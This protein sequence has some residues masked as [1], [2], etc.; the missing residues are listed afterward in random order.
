M[1]FSVI[2]FSCQSVIHGNTFSLLTKLLILNINNIAH[3]DAI[4]DKKVCVSLKYK[5]L[6]FIKVYCLPEEEIQTLYRVDIF[7]RKFETKI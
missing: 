6:L 1:Y 4:Q 7:L 2:G 3:F 5:K